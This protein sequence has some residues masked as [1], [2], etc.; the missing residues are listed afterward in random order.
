MGADFGS[1]QMARD[2]EYGQ[3]WVV[4][5][6]RRAGKSEY[7]RDGKGSLRYQSWRAWLNMCIFT[8]SFKDSLGFI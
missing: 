5:L 4:I 7:H 6:E 2:E 1:C 3:V 8:V